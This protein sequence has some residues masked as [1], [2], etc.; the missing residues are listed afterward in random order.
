LD[1]FGS[2][3]RGIGVGGATWTR[4]IF[5][6]VDERER[7]RASSVDG[8]ALCR[9]SFVDVGAFRFLVCLGTAGA[10]AKVH[11]CDARRSI[12]RRTDGAHRGDDGDHAHNG[13]AAKF[14]VFAG[15]LRVVVWALEYARA[16]SRGSWPRDSIWRI[17]DRHAFES[18]SSRWRNGALNRGDL[19]RL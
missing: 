3:S 7:A 5:S 16:G 6:S 13:G 12:C 1:L 14:A 8:I 9:A 10:V 11:S 17:A 19:P 4:R 2:R 15:A 18:G